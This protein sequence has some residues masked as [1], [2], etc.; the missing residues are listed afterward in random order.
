MS[1]FSVAERLSWA[2]NRKTTRSEDRAY[3]LLGIFG[4][5]MCLLYGEGEDNSLSRL[6]KKVDKA[7]KSE[8]KISGECLVWW[9][10]HALTK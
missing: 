10:T 2:Q 6:R 7:S 3:S 5:Y 8:H 1:Q 9:S 4:I